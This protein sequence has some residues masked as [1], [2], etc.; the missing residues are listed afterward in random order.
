MLCIG[1][2]AQ[3]VMCV[4]RVWV[5]SG[6]VGPGWTG[7]GHLV[8]RRGRCPVPD[9]KPGPLGRDWFQVGRRAGERAGVIEVKSRPL[10]PRPPHY[11]VTEQTT[12]DPDSRKQK[13]QQDGLETATR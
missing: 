3:R 2:L 12:R 1:W 4:F 5:K 8:G 9:P 7:L 11:R 6:G 13:D 10:K